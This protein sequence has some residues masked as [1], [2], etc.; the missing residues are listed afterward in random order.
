MT[1]QLLAAY[2]KVG[3]RVLCPTAGKHFIRESLDYGCDVTYLTADPE[4][5]A[6]YQEKFGA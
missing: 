6:W 4:K 3:D 1:Q 5:F 2:C